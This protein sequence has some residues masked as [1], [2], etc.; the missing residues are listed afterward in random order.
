MEDADDEDNAQKELILKAFR[1]NLPPNRTNHVGSRN[2]GGAQVKS[3]SNIRQ[4][5]TAIS[6]Q[7]FVTVG[8]NITPSMPTTPDQATD[9]VASSRKSKNK[10]LE[11]AASAV[12]AEIIEDYQHHSVL[13][14][15]AS[16]SKNGETDEDSKEHE[17]LEHGSVASSI[18]RLVNP[19]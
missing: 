17:K 11:Y 5:T 8:R 10:I 15:S 12:L 1:V 13:R 4:S 14:P 2:S 3:P 7:S 16:A 9:E 6:N 19:N 18:E